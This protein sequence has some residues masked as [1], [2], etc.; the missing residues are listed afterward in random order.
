MYY[1]QHQTY[2]SNIRHLGLEYPALDYSKALPFLL[3][4]PTAVLNG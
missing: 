3:M 1:N 2:Y 4:L